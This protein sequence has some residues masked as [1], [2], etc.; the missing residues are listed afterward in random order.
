MDYQFQERSKFALMTVNN[1]FTDL[2][3]SAFQLCDGTWIMPGMPVP[4]IGIWKKWLGSIR[5]ERLGRANL[6]LFV[7]EPSDNPGIL[8]DVHQRL[9]GDLRLLFSMLHLRVGIK[10]KSAD[11][12]CG[13]SVNGVPEI[14]QM[15]QMPDSYQSQGYMR[16]PIIQAWLE[17]GLVLRAG[18]AT[19]ETDRKRFRARRIPPG[20]AEGSPREGVREP[21]AG[22]Q[23]WRSGGREA[24]DRVVAHLRGGDRDGLEAAARGMAL[25]PACAALAGQPGAPRLSPHRWHADFGG[26]DR[27]RDRH[28]RSD[29]ARQGRHRPEVAPAH[30][31]GTGMG[32]SDG[33]PARQPLRPDRPGARSAGEGRAAHAGGS[34]SRGRVRDRYGSGIERAAGREAGLR[35]SGADG[36]ALWRGPRGALWTEIDRDEGVWTIPAPRTKGNR[37]HR[38]PLCR[39]ALEVLEEARALARGNPLVFPSVGGKPIGSTAMSELLRAL[40]IT[41]VPHGFRSSFRDW[42][43]EETDHPREVAEAALAH[44]VRNQIEAA[45]RR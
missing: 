39:R 37:E 38:V 30:P 8:D 31:R 42:T 33:S 41:A 6:V 19:M 28:P 5:L 2:S 23:G 11:L 10:M 25:S 24:S 1:V 45:Y 40:K 29:L 18:A 44:K 15:S 27:G 26:D 9:S 14:R 20:I 43:A 17:D 3:T 12:L 7:E 34:A 36:H 21:E 16:A 32:R 4:D 13:S 35:V 22:P